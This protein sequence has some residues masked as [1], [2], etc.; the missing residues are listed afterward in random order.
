MASLNESDLGKK[1]LIFY[2]LFVVGERGGL[3]RAGERKKKR[4]ETGTDI[5]DS[6]F[7]MNHSILEMQ[8]TEHILLSLLSNIRILF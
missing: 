7:I 4:E 8:R 3:W 2:Y 1:E 5:F 6:S